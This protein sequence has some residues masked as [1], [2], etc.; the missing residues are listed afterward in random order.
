MCFLLAFYI[1]IYIQY[2]KKSF[3]FSKTI[4]CFIFAFIINNKLIISKIT[5][6]ILFFIEFQ[7]KNELQILYLEKLDIEKIAGNINISFVIKYTMNKS[8]KINKNGI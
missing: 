5:R 3:Y 4:Y 7:I 2:S 1:K 8:D 6:Y